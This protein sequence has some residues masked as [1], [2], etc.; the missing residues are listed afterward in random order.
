LAVSFR[1]LYDDRYGYPG[2]FDLEYCTDCDHR[3]LRADFSNTA[4]TR[5]YSDFY[6]RSSLSLD[7]HR[8]R[9][10]ARGFAAWLA[11]ERSAAYQWVPPRVRILDIGCGFG[12]T[13]GYHKARGCDVQ[14]VE[15]DENI[16]RV[17]ERF[18]YDVR[19]GLFDASLYKPESFDWVTMDQVLEHVQHPI[20]VLSGIATILKPGGHLVIAVPNPLG[21]G[22]RVFGRRWINW[23]TPYHL[24]FFSKRSMQE[25]AR[26]A[27]LTVERT[28]TTTP[29]AWLRFQW[30]HLLTVP[31]PSTPSQFWN[32]VA[33]FEGRQR[34]ALRLI[35]LGD[36]VRASEWI[37]R[38]FDGLGL[39]DSRLYFLRKT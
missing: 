28:K 3:F 17:A 12:E 6:P 5:L 24:Q 13:L 10:E 8:P 2:L 14:G 4:I 9:T 25:A 11:G 33:K 36:R 7:D 16:R 15:A 21:W 30:F 1:G 31:P 35:N 26:A 38:F 27:G 19:V 34:L 23:H 22:A 37:T 32:H 39:G 29:S 20:D 18:G